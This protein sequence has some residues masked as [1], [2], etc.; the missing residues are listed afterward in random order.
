M[1]LIFDSNGCP[2]KEAELI[3][4]SYVDLPENLKVYP[5]LPQ[6]GLGFKESVTLDT[7]CYVVGDKNNDLVTDCSVVNCVDSLWPRAILPPQISTASGGSRE[8]RT[9]CVACKR[10]VDATCFGQ[11]SDIKSSKED[12]S[13]YSPA[14]ERLTNAHSRVSGTEPEKQK[15]LILSTR[16]CRFTSNLSR[17]NNSDAGYFPLQLYFLY[18]VVYCREGGWCYF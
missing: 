7:S 4:S 17:L 18:F 16:E 15:K 5:P 9:I 12:R 14:I 2:K 3:A 6:D 13:K 10:G 11:Q 8:S 1:R